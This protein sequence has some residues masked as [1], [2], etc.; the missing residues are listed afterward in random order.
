MEPQEPAH[1]PRWAPLLLAAISLLGI[2]LA[3]GP[4]PYQVDDASITY[5]YAARLGAGHGLAFNPGDPPVEGFS[6]PLWLGLLSLGALLA[7]PGAL[8]VQAFFMGLA[9]LLATLLLAAGPHREGK[10]APGLVAAALLALNP[11]VL[12]YAATGLES[13]LFLLAVIAFARS[14]AG[15][16]HPAA[17]AAAGLLAPWIRPEGAW[18]LPVLL[19][20]GLTGEPGRFLRDRRY[21]VLA[22]AVVA[23]VASLLAVRLA[24]YGSWLPNTYYAKP[25]RLLPA[26]AYAGDHLGSRWGLGLLLCA[27]LG[28]WAGDRRRLGYLLAGISW[29]A[30]AILEGGDWMPLGRMLLPAFGLFALAAAGMFDPPRSGAPAWRRT[31]GAGVLLATLLAGAVATRTATDT[32]RRSWDRAVHFEEVLADWVRRSGS[33]SVA[34]VDIGRFGFLAPVS[35]VDLAGLTDA[36]IGRAPGAHLAKRFDLDYLFVR[37]RPDL[38]VIKVA[39]EP[40]LLP[41]GGVAL[42]TRSAVENRVMTDPRMARDYR[43]LVAFLPPRVSAGSVGKLVFARTGTVVPAGLV[44]GSRIIRVGGRGAS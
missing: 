26:L 40:R 7:G 25:A 13:V 5:R 18:L 28:A 9:A 44:P 35:I 34:T 17:G 11:G 39:S 31:A 19:V 22:G 20:L 6:S 36:V 42:Q 30:A 4:H 1:R 38:V 24:L 27:L 14:A 12:F 21:R 29:V 32:A 43:F 23:G 2:G 37:R 10:A 8:P 41:G 16:L 33:R 15:T 3:L